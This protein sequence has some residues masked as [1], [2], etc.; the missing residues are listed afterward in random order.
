[1]RVLR[2]LGL[3]LDAAASANTVAG[4]ETGENTEPEET[5]EPEE[6]IV[7]KNFAAVSI[8]LLFIVGAMSIMM[9]MTKKNAARNKRG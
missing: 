5:E 8:G 4:G 7:E 3:S 9:F 2:R 1:M 6:N